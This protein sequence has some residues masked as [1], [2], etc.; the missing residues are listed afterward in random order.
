MRA[1]L[2]QYKT[3]IKFIL[4]FLIVYI[5]LSLLYKAYL[6]YAINT[7]YYPDYVTNLVAKQVGVLLNDIGYET[8]VLEHSDEPSIKLIVNGKYLARII[9][10]CNSLSVIIL[11]LAFVVA[12]AGRLKT[13][14]LYVI[15]GAVLIY[16]VNLV[17]I[18]FF[19]VALY[20]YPWRS[21]V[22]H[23]VVFP[24]IIYGIVCLLWVLWVNRFS[25]LSRGNE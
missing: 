10:G 5:V 24:G 23:S 18:V 17:R 2:I 16:I 4:T 3:V 25:N 20:H 11:F 8:Q 9:E 22:L 14:I 6:Q 21:E 19:A 7:K 1:L 12:F 15:C 13:T